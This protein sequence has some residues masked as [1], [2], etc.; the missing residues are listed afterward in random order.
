MALTKI[1]YTNKETLNAQ[2]SIADKNKCTSGDLNEIKSV[3]NNAIDQVDTNTI[4]IGN[5][6]TSIS[7][8][9]QSLSNIM[10][11]S[12][13]E[14]VIGTWVDGKPLYRQVL[15]KTLSG[16]QNQVVGT[17]NNV[18]LLILGG[19]SVIKYDSGG[20]NYYTGNPNSYEAAN[21]WTKTY[22]MINRST[23]TCNVYWNGSEAGEIWV[24]CLYTKSTD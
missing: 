3:V 17:I 21:N 14:K 6:T 8:A 23:H 10:D 4:D 1:Q 22:T 2:P 20:T 7:G 13:T 18:D 5:M 12:T 15:H 16:A 11:Y 19:S 24:E 9:L